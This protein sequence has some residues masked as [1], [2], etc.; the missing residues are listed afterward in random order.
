MIIYRLLPGLTHGP[1]DAN[2]AGVA[3]NVATVEFSEP[4]VADET[5]SKRGV[6]DNNYCNNYWTG[7]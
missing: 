4:Y 6:Y 3:R 1:R 5:A 7:W 2:Y